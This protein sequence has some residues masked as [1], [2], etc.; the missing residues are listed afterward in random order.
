M[1]WE[2]TRFNL[3]LEDYI[4]TSRRPIPQLLNKKAYFIARRSLWNTTKTAPGRVV[5]ELSEP[6]ELKRH[7]SESGYS[8]DVFGQRRRAARSDTGEAPRIV[9]IIQRRQS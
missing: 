9:G 8:F 2:Q 1:S 3:V 7:A 5:R 4:K 6:V